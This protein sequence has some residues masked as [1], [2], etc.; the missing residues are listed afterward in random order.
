M[1]IYVVTLEGDEF[2]DLPGAK[3]SYY[4]P[5]D[6]TDISATGAIPVALASAELYAAL[7]TGVIDGVAAEG[8]ISLVGL[9]ST[10][11]TS[12]AP[13]TSVRKV[14]GDQLVDADSDE[15]QD[16]PTEGDDVLLG[17]DDKDVIKL[18]GG[19]DV[20]GAGG[21][22]DK[23]YGGAGK[24]NISGEGGKDKLFGGKGKDFLFG[25]KGDD[26]LEGGKGNDGLTGG[27][28]DDYLDGGKGED[29]LKGGKGAD[30]FVFET[31]GGKN[32]DI[33]EDFTYGEDDLIVYENYESYE[34]QDSAVVF[35]FADGDTLTFSDN[36]DT[37]PTTLV[38]AFRIYVETPPD[39]ADV[40][41][42]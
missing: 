19:D 15:P 2:T 8:E 37:D 9:Q 38:R 31:M 35:T 12:G 3:L 39:T 27:K 42:L 6:P 10:L 41:I 28:G 11:A 13:G 14:Q 1:T 22:R 40:F 24:D 29:I 7:L 18:L 26:R 25:G 5:I 16:G 17:T 33:I 21:G 32:H 23:V 36:E 34:I 30:T 4:G 20:Y